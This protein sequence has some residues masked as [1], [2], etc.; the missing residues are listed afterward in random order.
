M[1]IHAPPASTP[2]DPSIQNPNHSS[3]S[4]PGVHHDG[5]A[6]LHL[7]TRHAS[8]PELS[9]HR[10]NL[11]NANTLANTGTSTTLNATA[12]AANKT[13]LAGVLKAQK[14][15]K[16]FTSLR[17]ISRLESLPP[18]HVNNK[19]IITNT[20]SSANNSFTNSATSSVH[21]KGSDF[22]AAKG[23][24]VQTLGTLPRPGLSRASTATGRSALSGMFILFY[25]LFFDFPSCMPCVTCTFIYHMYSKF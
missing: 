1:N 16:N 23:K 20:A 25:R 5:A 9:A 14:A 6:S 11:T 19:T 21:G 8:S 10:K 7:P 2:V 15:S 17:S 4:V 12:T 13:S 3:H 24:N 22:G 18:I